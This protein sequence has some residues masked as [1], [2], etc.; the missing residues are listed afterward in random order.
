ME[1]SEERKEEDKKQWVDLFG[2]YLTR[3]KQY[4]TDIFRL[5]L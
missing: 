2:F 4:I 5:W 3:F 1:G